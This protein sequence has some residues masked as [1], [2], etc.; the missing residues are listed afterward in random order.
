MTADKDS[1]QL[2]LALARSADSR[3]IYRLAANIGDWNSLLN[4]AREHRVLPLLFSRITEIVTVLP[5]AVQDQL[6]AEYDNNMLH[7][8]ASA[9]ELVAVIRDFE[10]ATIPA[11]PFKGVVLAASIYRD[12]LARPAGD[13]DLLI[14]AEHLTQA[15]AILL[16][17]GYELKTPTHPDGTPAVADYYEYHFERQTDGMILELRWRLELTQPRFRHNLGMDWVWPR[18]RT[19]VVAGVE[20]PDMSPEITLLILCMHGSKHAW[21]RLIWICDVAQLLH[22][23]RALDW[24]A[25]IRE[26]RRSGLL[27]A[28][29]LGALLA[30]RVVGAALPPDVLRRFE[31]DATACTLARHF[32]ENLFSSPGATPSGRMPYNIQLLGRR[33]QIMFFLSRDFLRP[34]ERDRAVL[35]LPKPLHSLYYLVRPFRLFWDRSSR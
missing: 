5:L 9:A 30:H 31:A 35:P 21:S 18:R 10:Q 3:Q 8:L 26:A 29:A 20:V 24:Q 17:R 23:S 4:L 6:R 2:L 19:A 32:Q 11:M 13:L 15:T 14:N 1:Q 27:R 7:N 16:A 33:D 25:V 28:L 34:N 12:L 22:I